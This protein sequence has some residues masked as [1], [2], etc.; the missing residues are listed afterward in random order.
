MARRRTPPTPE[1]G[2]RSRTS[3]SSRT[4]SAREGLPD[5]C[6]NCRGNTIWRGVPDAAM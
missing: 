1:T 6:G 5:V 4:T 2:S 3:R